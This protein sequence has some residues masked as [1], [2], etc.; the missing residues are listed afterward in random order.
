[1]VNNEVTNIKEL[2]RDKALTPLLDFP[3]DI[4]S[5]QVEFPSN[6]DQS[7]F[8]TSPV[9]SKTVIEASSSSQGQRV[10]PTYSQQSRSPSTKL[11]ISNYSTLGSF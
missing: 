6:L 8:T 3:F 9:P 4:I 5:E 7:P 10:A 2:E 11:N 1:M